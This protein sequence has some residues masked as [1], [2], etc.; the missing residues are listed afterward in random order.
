M[1]ERQRVLLTGA[2]GHVGGRL[3]SRLSL[4]NALRTRAL[5][6]SS[7]ALPVWAEDTE[8]LY[9]NLENRRIRQDALRDVNC[10]VH[11]ATRG[12]SSVMAPTEEEL[13]KEEELTLS[14]AADAL[15]ARVSRLIYISSIH[16]YGQALVGRVDDL[17]PTAPN[18][19]YGRSRQRIEQGILELASGFDG[20]VAVLR[21]TNSFGVPAI[22]RKE[23][24]NLLMHDLCRQVVQSHSMELRSDGRISRD[25]MALR[26]VVDV[27]YQ[28]ITTTADLQGVCLL[29]SGHTMQL[30]EIAESVQQHAKEVLGVTADISVPTYESVQPASFS[31]HPAKLLGAGITIPRNRDKEIRDLLRYAQQEFGGANS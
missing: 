24:W 9:G 12:F 30:T 25:I 7:R 31:L 28:I 10:V 23:T 2:T 16:A 18:T 5:V 27:L 14:L 13:A 8:V 17:T 20:Q 26:D 4:Q 1:A 19:H 3:L 21:L 6:R 22:P 29:A 11:L 15:G